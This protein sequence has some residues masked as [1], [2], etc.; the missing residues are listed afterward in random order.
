MTKETMLKEMFLE[1]GQ[2]DLKAIGRSRGFDPQ[3]IASP[4][5]MQHVFLS[6]QGVAA[7]LASL[8]ETES[9]GLHL[10]NCFQDEVDVEFFRKMYPDSAPRNSFYGSYTERFHGLFQQVKTQLIRRGVLLFGTLTAN[11]SRGAVSF[12]GG[13][14]FAVAGPVQAQQTEHGCG[15]TVS[16]GT[17]AP[18]SGGDTDR[19]SRFE[20]Q[21]GQRGGTLA[22]G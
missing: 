5:L 12:S 3:T 21:S 4:Q 22:T 2:A 8:S 6:E 13:V 1:L 14:C 11:E 15:A 16:P 10:L 9:L 20:R 17:V 7:A 19:G 18:K